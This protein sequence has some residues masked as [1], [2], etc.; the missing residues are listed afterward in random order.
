M[1][2]L[3]TFRDSCCTLYATDMQK[4]RHI[5]KADSFESAFCFISLSCVTPGVADIPIIFHFVPDNVCTCS[6]IHTLFF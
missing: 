4:E 5:R 6:G 3:V 1:Q 2:G